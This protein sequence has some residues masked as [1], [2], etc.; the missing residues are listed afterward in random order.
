MNTEKQIQKP[1]VLIEPM[2]RHINNGHAK[3]FEFRNNL[4]AVQYFKDWCIKH[5]YTENGSGFQA[6]GIGYDYRIECF[7]NY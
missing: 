7:L 6:G 2:Q 5:S 4:E 1:F 3:T